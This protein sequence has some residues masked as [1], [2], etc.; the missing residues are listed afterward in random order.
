MTLNDRVNILEEKPVTPPKTK[1]QFL[2][3]IKYYWRDFILVPIF[4]ISLWGMELLN[5]P[6]G[7][8]RNIA[9]PFDDQ[10]PLLTWT[11]LIYNTWAPTMVVLL[12]YYFF[13][14]RT[15]MRRYFWTMQVG[16]I[17][18]WATFP[19]F[20][21]IIP[22]PYDEVFAGTDIF[23][24]MLTITY[25]NDNHFC[26]FPSIHVIQCTL[27]IIFIW[28]LKE[29]PR[30]LKVLVTIYF[31]AIAA[32]TVTTKQHVFL[33]IPGGFVYALVAFPLAIPLARWYEKRVVKDAYR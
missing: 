8:V 20:Q 2:A 27:T 12:F 22:R 24:K 23:S 6:I 28:M 9:I 15:M 7:T 10:I 5:R 1:A 4:F 32:T 16:Q 30:W 11:V 3:Y 29:A 25:K 21:T 18:A 31:L 13:R 17:M 33:D 26:G 19:L 14:N